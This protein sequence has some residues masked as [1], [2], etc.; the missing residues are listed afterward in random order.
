VVFACIRENT[1][2]TR[3]GIPEGVA[4]GVMGTGGDFL[5]LLIR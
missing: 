4:R 1:V 2:Q 3:A 5:V